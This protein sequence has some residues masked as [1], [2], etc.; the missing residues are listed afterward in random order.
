[1]RR[2]I[3]HALPVP[4][5]RERR[6]ATNTLRQKRERGYRLFASTSWRAQVTAA[7]S[8]CPGEGGP[9]RRI[10]PANTNRRAA[11]VDGQREPP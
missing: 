5:E 4:S 10:D 9:R 6:P 3:V 2:I 11:R 1:M 8:D 7:C